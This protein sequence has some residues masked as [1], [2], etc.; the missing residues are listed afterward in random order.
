MSGRL[1]CQTPGCGGLMA[2]N[3]KVPLCDACRQTTCYLCRGK[4]KPAS[5]PRCPDCLRAIRERTL[6]KAGRVC[7][8][9]G[10]EPLPR[11]TLCSAC[12][13]AEDQFYR[14]QRARRREPHC[15]VCGVSVPQGY[16]ETVCWPCRERRRR[17]RRRRCSWCAKILRGAE[18]GYCN[19]CRR[20][21][22]K[23]DRVL[24]KERR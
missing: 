7:R 17:L 14:A 24:A 3:R 1:V 12:K 18:Q 20:D 8:E 16:Q 11:A 9:C 10:E 5:D 21:K 22:R 15:G 23:I 6:A 13:A 2:E 4:K 19:P